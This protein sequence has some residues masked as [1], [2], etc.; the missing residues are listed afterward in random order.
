[1]WPGGHLS[2]RP[3]GIGVVLI[4]GVPN[5]DEIVGVAIGES[6]VDVG[7]DVNVGLGVGVHV[8]ITL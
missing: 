3:V 1:M 8:A 4:K 6:I 5:G 2:Y 7:S